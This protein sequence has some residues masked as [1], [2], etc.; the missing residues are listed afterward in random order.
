[1]YKWGWQSSVNALVSHV[2]IK[3]PKTQPMKPLSILRQQGKLRELFSSEDK[4]A[5]CV[6]VYTAKAEDDQNTTSSVSI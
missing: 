6:E 2:C 3:I 1:M 5:G 4:M